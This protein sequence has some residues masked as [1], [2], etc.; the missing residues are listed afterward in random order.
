MGD[1]PPEPNDFRNRAEWSLQLNGHYKGV[2]VPVQPDYNERG[3]AGRLAAFC[4]PAWDILSEG[5]GFEKPTFSQIGLR[6]RS[7][8]DFG[9]RTRLGL[10][11]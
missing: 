5:K 7:V 8:A 10:T 1:N 9:R 2:P 11:R 3:K 4:F 6:A